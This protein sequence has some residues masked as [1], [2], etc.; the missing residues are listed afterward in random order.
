[1][2]TFKLTRKYDASGVS[3]VGTVLEGVEFSDGSVVI[4]WLTKYKS[5]GIYPSYSEFKAVHIDSH[6]DNDS[7]IIWGKK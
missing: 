4:S 6:P 7:E 3:G 2:N 1:M 5:L